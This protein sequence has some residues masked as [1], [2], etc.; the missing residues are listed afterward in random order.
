MIEFQ[1]TLPV[2][3]ETK[4][5]A[6]KLAEADDFN[7]LS[8]CGERH[9]N[10]ADINNCNDFNPLSPCGERRLKAAMEDYDETISTHSPRVGRDHAPHGW[11]GTGKEFQ[12]TLPVW[13]ETPQQQL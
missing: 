5:Q 2:W 7:P 13:G 3:G 8:P 9:N 1:P 6:Q 12:P 11:R 10:I 4:E